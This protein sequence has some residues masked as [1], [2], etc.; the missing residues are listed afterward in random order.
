M[1]FSHICHFRHMT[2]PNPLKTQIFDPFPTQ[3]NPTQRAG[4]PNPR[5]LCACL[6]DWSINCNVAGWR[7]QYNSCWR[8][9]R[10]PEHRP[11]CF[12][13]FRPACS[14]QQVLPELCI[15]CSVSQYLEVLQISWL[16]STSGH[17]LLQ[18]QR[19]QQPLHRRPSAPVTSQSIGQHLLFPD[20][21]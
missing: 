4:Q 3:P 2:Q 17:W 11:P 20:K 19:H 9:T 7:S 21:I 8:D 15:R 13:S 14:V 5:T 18:L 6:I 12:H 10:C 16:S 1:Y